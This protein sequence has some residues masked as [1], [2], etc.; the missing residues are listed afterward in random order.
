MTSAITTWPLN[1]DKPIETIEELRHHLANAIALEFSTIPLY[2]YPLYSIQ[3][4]GYSQWSAGMSA[5]RTIRSV[6]IEE[7]LHLC[8]A[9]NLMIAVG[10][11]DMVRFYSRDLMPEYPSPMLHRLP[12]LMLHLEPCSEAL[13]TDVFMPL[14][15]PARTDAP[16]EPGWYHTIGEF[17][18]AISAGFTRLDGPDLWAGN[19]P[20]LQYLLGY[21]N[22]D[23]GG[24]PLV[25]CDLSSA[26]QAIRTIVEQGEGSR[27]GQLVV[28]LNPVKPQAGMDEL[29]HYGKFRQI[30]EGIDQIGNVW[31]VPVDPPPGS[32]DGPVGQLAR[33]F[34]AAYCYLLCLLDALYQTTRMTEG[35][36]HTS[37]RYAMERT[38]IAAMGGILYP[39][40]TLLVQQPVGNGMHAAPTFGYYDFAEDR[41]KRDQL[42]GLCAQTAA[43]YPTLG[44]SDSVQH[45]IGLL[46]SV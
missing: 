23:G 3:T 34:D 38:F 46:P 18:D 44:G 25:V 6:V 2:L 5:L 39:I 29:S 20:D 7:M 43:H 26:R 32:W 21:W 35:P 45:L 31:P 15:L 1:P 30:A 16:P 40:A 19:Q 13:M 42:L 4:E 41:S 28:P 24:S 9:R 36:G 33:L 27:P 37:P 14:E 11:G 17:Y 8:L 22:Q 10:G 12:K